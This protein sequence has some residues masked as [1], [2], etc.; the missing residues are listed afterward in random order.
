MSTVTEKLKKKCLTTLQNIILKTLKF[1]KKS[2]YKMSI[3]K[4][5]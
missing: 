1:K 3:L 4:G 5:S 2:Q